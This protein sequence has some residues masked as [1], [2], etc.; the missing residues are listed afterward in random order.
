MIYFS[1]DFH[2][3]HFSIIKNC[4]RPFS[5]IE[6]IN[7]TLINRTPA[8]FPSQQR[9]HARYIWMDYHKKYEMNHSA[10]FCELYDSLRDCLNTEEEESDDCYYC[11]NSNE[12][13]TIKRQLSVIRTNCI[14]C[15]DRTNVIQVCR[16]HHRSSSFSLPIIYRLISA[17]GCLLN[18]LSYGVFYLKMSQKML[19]KSRSK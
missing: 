2:I 3:N 5:S 10:S 11:S 16:L 7:N 19:W 9:I 8:R 1:S 13:K 17:S 4:N 6:E 14:D 15:L 18:S 12:N